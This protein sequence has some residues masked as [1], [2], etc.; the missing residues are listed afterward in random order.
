MSLITF[1]D[2]LQLYRLADP[3]SPFNLNK[4]VITI[5]TILVIIVINILLIAIGII[6]F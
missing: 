5:I 3:T 6:M 2:G 4:F 1:R